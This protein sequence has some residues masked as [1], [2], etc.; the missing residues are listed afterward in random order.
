MPRTR[1][2]DRFYEIVR[3]GWG[4]PP[5]LFE[6]GGSPPDKPP[7]GFDPWG[8]GWSFPS[9]AAVMVSFLLGFISANLL[10]LGPIWPAAL[11]LAAA[12]IAVWTAVNGRWR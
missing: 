11:L 6:G 4:D 9:W 5:A 7:R 8:R 1:E 2:R 12:L 10:V 3:A